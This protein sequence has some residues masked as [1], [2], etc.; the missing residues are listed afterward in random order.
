MNYELP[1][2]LSILSSNYWHNYS[3]QGS[4]RKVLLSCIKFYVTLLSIGQK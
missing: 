2:A 4:I 3:I 1:A